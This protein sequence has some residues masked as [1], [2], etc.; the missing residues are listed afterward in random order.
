MVE[1]LTEH[2]AAS[3]R[4]VIGYKTIERLRHVVVATAVVR[5][6]VVGVLPI[7]VVTTALAVATVV[8][9]RIR[10][11]MRPGVICLKFQAVAETFLEADLKRVVVLNAVRD[12]ELVGRIVSQQGWITRQ[13]GTG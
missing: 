12:G 10:Q 11:A 3:E 2:A 13:V 5:M 9:D 8:P 6:S 4:Y 1:I 7:V